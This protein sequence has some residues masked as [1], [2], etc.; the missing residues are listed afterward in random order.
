VCYLHDDSET[1]EDSFGFVVSAADKTEFLKEMRANFEI[2][3]LLKNDNEPKRV[4]DKPFQVETILHV[5]HIQ[6]WN[7]TDYGIYQ[8]VV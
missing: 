2:K 5:I 7:D 1:E 3:I 6:C 4:R 8:S